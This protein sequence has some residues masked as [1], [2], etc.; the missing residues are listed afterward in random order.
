VPDKVDGITAYL[1]VVT[2]GKSRIV[3]GPCLCQQGRIALPLARLGR[4][5]RQLRLRDAPARHIRSVVDPYVEEMIT[6]L[7]VT[8]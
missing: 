1:K 5:R 3:V 6:L 7:K 8:Q 4:D 2:L